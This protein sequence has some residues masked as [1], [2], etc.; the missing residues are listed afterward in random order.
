M[1]KFGKTHKSYGVGKHPKSTH[2]TPVDNAIGKVLV[3]VLFI[4]FLALDILAI[5]EFIMLK[6]EGKFKE[7]KQ[8]LKEKLIPIVAL[9]ICLVV[10]TAILVGS[11]VSKF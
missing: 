2:N 7:N 8:L 5:R 6:K 4:L 1:L 9:T 3:V 11:I 10:L